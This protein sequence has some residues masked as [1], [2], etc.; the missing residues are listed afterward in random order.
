[1]VFVIAWVFFSL[2]VASYHPPETLADRVRVRARRYDAWQ[3]DPRR[4]TRRLL[5]V[6]VPGLVAGGIL[7]WRSAKQP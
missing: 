2:A 5:V 4:D 1:M 7:L 3:F 6:L